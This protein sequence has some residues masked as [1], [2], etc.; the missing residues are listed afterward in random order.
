MPDVFVVQDYFRS[1]TGL[2]MSTYFSAYKYR[3]L[4]ENVPAVKQAVD[5]HRCLI[6]TMDTWIIYNLTGGINGAPFSCLNPLK[7]ISHTRSD[8][9]RCS[10]HSRNAACQMYVWVYIL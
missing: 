4:V 9:K 10:V 5:E 6:G 7:D 3:W 8:K 1:V 2:P